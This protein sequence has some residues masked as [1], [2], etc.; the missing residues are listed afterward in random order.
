MLIAE[1]VTSE[2][3][4]SFQARTGLIVKRYQRILEIDSNNTTILEEIIY[5]QGQAAN[6]KTSKR[7]CTID[8]KNFKWYHNRKE[9]EDKTPLGVIPLQFI[10]QVVASKMAW[11]ENPS[12]SIS[13]TQWF[14]KHEEDEGRRDFFFACDNILQLEKWIITIEYLRTRSVYEAYTKKNVPVT[15]PLSI[16]TDVRK[17]DDRKDYSEIVF[18]FSKFLR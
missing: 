8:A 10:Y 16:N 2:D 5:K 6:K 4:L 17:R 1:D 12:F 13:T 15:F 9:L 11:L 18:D 3:Q 7:L 14:N